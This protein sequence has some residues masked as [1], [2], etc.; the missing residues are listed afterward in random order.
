MGWIYLLAAGLFEIVWAVGI[1]YV[2]GFKIN[3]TM[4]VVVVSMIVSTIF[5]SLSIK[6]IP[7]GIAYAVWSGIGIVGTFTY[8]LMIEKE[9]ITMGS[10]I[11]VLMIMVGIMGL[12]IMN[13]KE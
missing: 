6:Y 12:K 7:I 4:I 5:L 8:T 10:I 1:K 2:N 3:T 11:F 13:P 9:P